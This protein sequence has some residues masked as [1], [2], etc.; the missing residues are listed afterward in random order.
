MYDLIINIA[1]YDC[2]GMID[3]FLLIGIVIIVCLYIIY[4]CNTLLFG[5]SICSMILFIRYLSQKHKREYFTDDNRNPRT[6]IDWDAYGRL[7]Q[8]GKTIT[9]IIGPSLE[10]VITSVK[11]PDVLEDTGNEDAVNQEDVD[12]YQDPILIAYFQ[13]Q[14]IN[15][16]QL[17][18]YHKIHLVLSHL[19]RINRGV[20]QSLLNRLENKK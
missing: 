12:E 9:Q 15:K 3:V 18:K 14:G 19:K 11:G 16:D 2:K 5:L 20:Y 4:D 10:Y 6:I 1:L 13:K 7:A 17:D 8:I